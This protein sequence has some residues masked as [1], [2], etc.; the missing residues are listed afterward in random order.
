LEPLSQLPRQWH[1]QS[2]PLARRC[3]ALDREAVATGDD[4]HKHD[5]AR[6]HQARGWCNG[7]QAMA[8]RGIGPITEGAVQQVRFGSPSV[9]SVVP[10]AS[11]QIAS[12]ELRARTCS[13]CEISLAGLLDISH[14]MLFDAP[15]FLI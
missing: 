2:T 9:G 1:R 14:L 13:G 5:A 11:F 4:R 8:A 7:G 10:S 6:G 15:K 3:S 12:K